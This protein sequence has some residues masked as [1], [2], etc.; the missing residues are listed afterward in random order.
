MKRFEI[1]FTDQAID[2][3]DASFE[4]GCEIWGTAQAAKW[5]FEMRDRIIEQLTRSPLACPLTPQQHLYSAE[6]RV[7]VIGRYN[8]L[9]H[10]DGKLVTILHIRGPFTER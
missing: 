2:D 6:T 10:I 5:Y 9:F 7:L 4:W 3:L 1:E 8:V